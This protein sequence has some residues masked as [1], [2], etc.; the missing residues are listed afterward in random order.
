MTGPRDASFPTCTQCG[1]PLTGAWFGIR[2]KQ[3][4][5]SCGA[6]RMAEIVAG[7]TRAAASLDPVSS[8]QQDE[9][10]ETS[11]TGDVDR[12]LRLA[13]ATIR[14]AAIRTAVGEADDPKNPTVDW[15][16]GML[17]AA[18]LIDRMLGDD[19]ACGGTNAPQGDACSAKGGIES[20]A[21]GLFRAAALDIGVPMAELRG[22]RRDPRTVRARD[23]VCARL[24]AAGLSL[25]TIGRL[26]NRDHS[27]VLYALRKMADPA[28]TRARNKVRGQRAKLR[29]AAS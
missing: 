25:P 1:K 28:A 26:V 2:D 7:A 3:W 14:T 21:D 24:R 13:A 9:R 8:L 22:R 19:P 18:H 17:H 11:R 16:K 27:T 4:C 20:S 12:A 5:M 23:L 15:C 29:G 10:G 6:E